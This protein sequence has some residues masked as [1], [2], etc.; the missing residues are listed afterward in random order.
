LLHAHA[1]SEFKEL[2]FTQERLAEMLGAERTSISGIARVL[3]RFGSV[4]CRRG[5]LVIKD[6]RALEGRA[7]QCYSAIYIWRRL[8]GLAL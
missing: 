1:L 2:P 8:L 4:E 6:R 5:K 3:K 7:C